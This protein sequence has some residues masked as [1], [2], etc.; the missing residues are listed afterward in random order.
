MI[1]SGAPVVF[2]GRRFAAERSYGPWLVLQLVGTAI[3]IGALL[4]EWDDHSELTPQ[5]L[6]KPPKRLG[7]PWEADLRLKLRRVTSA[8]RRRWQGADGFSADRLAY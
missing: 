3:A 1:P 5:K 4:V 6:S 8:D 2:P 7:N